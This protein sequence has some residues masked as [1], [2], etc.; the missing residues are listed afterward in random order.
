M[1]GVFDKNDFSVRRRRK[2]KMDLEIPETVEGTGKR[3]PREEGEATGGE[4]RECGRGSE[5]EWGGD[6]S[7]RERIGVGRIQGPWT[8][9]RDRV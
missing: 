5:S 8:V 3:G 1:W 9:H 7:C 2:N 4:S 6:P